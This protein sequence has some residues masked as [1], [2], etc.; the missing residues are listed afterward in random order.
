[1]SIT[2]LTTTRTVA[3]KQTRF[4]DLRAAVDPLPRIHGLAH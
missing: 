3:A 4:R 1:M 2:D